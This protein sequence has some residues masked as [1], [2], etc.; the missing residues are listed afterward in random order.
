M[1]VK[2]LLVCLSM[3]GLLPLG[4]CN[5]EAGTS[6]IVPGV[7]PTPS[8]SEQAYLSLSIRQPN[9]VV[10]RSTTLDPMSQVKS[11][12]LLFY[13]SQTGVLKDIKDVTATLGATTHQ[14]SVKLQAGDYKLVALANP[15]PKVREQLHL[16]A[17]IEALNQGVSL[18]SGDLFN[19]GQSTLVMGNEQGVI[20]VDKSRFSHTAQESQRQAL[21][22]S[23]EPTLARVLVY[24]EPTLRAGTKKANKPVKYSVNNLPREVYLLRKLA[25][26]TTGTMERAG[27]QS[28]PQQRYAESPLWTVWGSTKPQNTEG[29]ANYP[30]SMLTA[31]QMNNEARVQIADYQADL[32][33]FTLYYK[34]STLPETAFLQGIAP[35]V[36]IAFPYIPNGLELDP[37][38]GWLSHQGRLYRQT[39]AVRLLGDVQSTDPLAVAFRREG[40]RAED[41]SKPEGFSR[42]GIQFYYQGYSYYTVFIKHF[43]NT[44]AYGKYGIVRGNEY[45]IQLLS[46]NNP[47][48]PTPISYD[49]NLQEIQ[50]RQ[51]TDF[52]VRVR[53]VGEINQTADL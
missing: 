38:E 20:V 10:L 11:L 48:S 23:I 13:D 22:L 35:Y 42:G 40:I 44:G 25:K 14:I 39:E 37:D 1:N 5:R 2:R 16:G 45:R 3:L 36:H 18:S 52:E 50:E 41:F 19:E 6:L 24:G 46:I 43:S 32:G 21:E 47:G 53:S 8:L 33:K 7:K 30:L 15:S 9:A 12:M 4:S 17:N 28:T 34:E 51:S 31:T 27:D 26:L 49:G 29:I